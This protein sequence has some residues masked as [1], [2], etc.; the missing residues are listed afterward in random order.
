MAKIREDKWSTVF[1]NALMSDIHKMSLSLA[2]FLQPSKCNCIIAL[3]TEELH[4][5]MSLLQVL[6][7]N[8]CANV[9]QL[10]RLLNVI[11]QEKKTVPPYLF[12]SQVRRFGTNPVTGGGFADI[13]KGEWQHK[14]VALKVLRIFGNAGDRSK[15]LQDFC[16]EAMVW[17]QLKHDHVVPFYG[18][19]TDVFSPHYAFVSP[20]M[21]NGDMVS[22]LKGHPETDRLAM[23]RGVALGLCY[24]HTRQP[25]VVHGDLRGVI[26]NVLIDAN[27]GPRISD[28]GLSKVIDSQATTV[29]VTSFDGRGAIR[30]QAPELLKVSISSTASINVS[31]KI[32][33]YAF[34]S[35][36]LEIFTCKLPFSHLRDG[37]VLTAVVLQDLRPPRPFEAMEIGLDDAVW[38]LMQDCWQ[39][40]PKSRPDM[41]DVVRRIPPFVPWI[42]VT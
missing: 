20:W 30:W 29:G 27:L 28:F 35:V 22:H 8:R 42:D 17:R 23:I 26:P 24:L 1:K 21:V 11:V 14:I 13:W 16:K 15:M 32:D 25:P 10:Q 37:Q 19:C 6:I 40:K 4:L 38:K 36:T 9:R 7:D 33:I 31:R 18:C 5:V 41:K 12:L 2:S 3:R 39:S 34:A